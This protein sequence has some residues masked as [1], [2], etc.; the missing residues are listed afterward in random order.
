MVV[1]PF[2]ELKLW[3]G[4]KKEAPIICPEEVCKAKRG[5]FKDTGMFFD[6]VRSEAQAIL[7]EAYLNNMSEEKVIFALHPTS[8]YCSSKI[9]KGDLQLYPVG[10]IQVVKPE[11][12]EKI[13]G[14]HLKYKG[15]DLQVVPYKPLTEF[16]LQ[17]QGYMVAYNWI[18]ENDDD[19]KINMVVK[20]QTIKGLAVP[21]LQ[22]SVPLN[23]HDVLYKGPIKS[24]PAAPAA[25]APSRKR[26]APK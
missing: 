13:K 17:K 16:S 25:K 7:N 5:D 6:W 10:I 12:V 1:T 14:L 20:W 8:L 2:H 11:D 21:V 9:K 3:K 18:Q 23:Q 15:I 26:K 24:S 19:E 4:T 22:N